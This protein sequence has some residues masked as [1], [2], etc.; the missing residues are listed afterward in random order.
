LADELHFG[1]TAE[2]L[3]ITHSRVSQTINQLEMRMNA[4]LFER[5]SRHVRLTPIG[6]QLQERIGPAL[7]QIQ[8]AY[9]EL[10]ELTNGVVGTLR[11]GI[12]AHAFA[13]LAQMVEI[14]RVF[15]DRHPKCLVRVAD[16]GTSPDPFEWLRRG[17][18]DIMLARLPIDAP[19]LVVGPTVSTEPRVLAVASSHPL[20]G[21]SS[22]S[23]EDLADYSTT[24]TDQMPPALM[25]AGCPPR[26][27][28]GRPMQ[29]TTVMSVVET[30]LRVATGELIHPTVPSFFTRFSHFGLVG[31]PIDDLPES[32]CALIWLRSNSS[33]K[34]EAF[35]LAAA[36]TSRHGIVDAIS[37]A[38][39]R[40]FMTARQ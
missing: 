8:G 32:H 12:Q 26:T 31:V 5:S 28:A 27:R 9:A 19:D 14:V 35:C 24:Y 3:G 16:I 13:G 37:P 6:Q 40:A 18:L 34:V 21:R 36:D 25:N 20:A 17:E 7:A 2:K 11:L 39:A 4:K 29:R 15:E 10:A 22:V 1:R 38:S 23:I 30:A 33:L